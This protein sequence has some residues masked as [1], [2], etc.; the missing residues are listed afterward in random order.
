[1]SPKP[2]AYISV[3]THIGSFLGLN[4]FSRYKFKK[5]FKHAL[6]TEYFAKVEYRQ[7]KKECRGVK[8]TVN[9][10]LHI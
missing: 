10:F 6:N 1:M 8:K 4:G 5:D 9:L 7:R 3:K 2:K